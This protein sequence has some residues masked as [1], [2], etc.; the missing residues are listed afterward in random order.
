ME[1]PRACVLTLEPH[2]GP[3]SRVLWHVVGCG[4][5]PQ[6]GP[7][8][9]RVRCLE[10]L[11]VRD[12]SRPDHCDRDPRPNHDGGRLLPPAVRWRS[13]SRRWVRALDVDPDDL[14]LRGGRR[15]K[16]LRPGLMAARCK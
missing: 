11:H 7:A 9:D 15:R 16:H 6:G 12:R 13:R 5:G 10:D 14:L 2:A 4:R 3:R 1:S 8:V